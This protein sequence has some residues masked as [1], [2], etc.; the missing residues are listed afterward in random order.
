MANETS[1]RDLI[2]RVRAR[3]E[4]AAAELVRRYES[5][6]RSFVRVRL[7]DP[8]LRRLFDSMDFCQAVL[9]SFFARAALGQYELDAPDQLQKVLVVIARN[10]VAEEA[11]KRRPDVRGAA[12]LEEADAVAP[13]PSDSQRLAARDLLAQVRR[14]LPEHARQLADLRAEGLLWPEIAARLG[15][16]PQALRKVLHRAVERVAR[17]LRLEGEP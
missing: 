5:V 2:R 17:D 13:G 15:G 7:R 11:R 4:T 10:K 14:R 6:V 1:F 8:G 3:D 9:A 12:P 16:K